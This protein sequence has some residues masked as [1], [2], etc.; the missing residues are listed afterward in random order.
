VINYER[1]TDVSFPE[2]QDI[3][4]NMM[5]FVMGEPDSLPL[6]LCHYQPLIDAC[7][8]EEEELG[9]VG[10]LTV[11]ET[12][13]EAGTSQRRGG[14]HTERHPSASWG[15]GGWGKGRWGGGGWG[16]G[17]YAGRRYGG[18]YLASN[19]ENTTAI[20]DARIEEPGEGG[21]VEH[22]IEDL[23]EPS[24]LGANELLWMTDATPHA[25]LPVPRSGKRQFFRVVTSAV[26]LWFADHS[27]AN[28]NVPLPE[29]V[30]Q[31]H[32]N[33]FA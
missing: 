31:I 22:I 10:Y 7:Q 28:P 33:K 27:T 26:D 25:S 21:D 20:W 29:T 32:G 14:A 6:E 3:L 17:I 16:K 13:V 2:S 12:E 11:T 5:P 19:M 8:I 4:V 9:K 1:I 30:K 15:G 18:I 23:G 24:V